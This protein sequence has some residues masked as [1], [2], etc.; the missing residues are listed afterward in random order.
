MSGDECCENP[1]ALS[2][3]SWGGSVVEVGGIKS[4]FSG[5]PDAKRAILLVSDVYGYEAPNLRKLADK[6]AEAGFY[7][8]VPDFLYGDP[9]DPSNVTRTLSV[10]SKSHRTDKGTADAELVIS[11]LASKGFSTIGAAG[12]C[13]GA[14]V[15]VE[16]AKSGRIQAAVLLHP[17]FVTMEDIK[18]V[19]TPIAILGAEIDKISPPE[20]INQFDKILSSKSEVN[21]FV[22]VF[23]GAKHGW[24]V[25]YKTEDERAV[26]RAEEAHQDMLGWFI[27][28]LL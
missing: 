12:F 20:L 14:K 21:S 15:V 22:K 13:W 3:N 19:R 8:L 25:R 4:Y 16:L 28:S 1:P 24:T 27:K 17:T 26:K 11:D 5:S 23:P 6:I 18:E 2:S 9:Y 7:V 10:W